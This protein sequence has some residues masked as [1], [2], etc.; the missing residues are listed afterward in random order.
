MFKKKYSAAL[1]VILLAAILI[2]NGCAKR[3]ST[4]QLDET[5]TK[6]SDATSQTSKSESRKAGD[7]VIAIAEPSIPSA[8]I[9]EEDLNAETAVSSAKFKDIRDIYFDFDMYSIRDDSR[10]ILQTNA[11]VIK[12]RKAKKVVIEGHCDDRGTN[13]YN[14]AL[15]ERRAQSAKRYLLALGVSPSNLST[16]SY[17]EEKPFCTEQNEECWQQNRRAHFVVE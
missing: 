1:P 5:G 4:S 11:S 6:P 15:G 10:S 3:V 8:D 14:L 17:G 16:I 12:N 7:D 9:H 2:T 13:E